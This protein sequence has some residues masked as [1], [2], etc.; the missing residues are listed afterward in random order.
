M[1]ATCCAGCENDCFA[2]HRDS[3]WLDESSLEPNEKKIT[4]AGVRHVLGFGVVF[5]PP[6]AHKGIAIAC[7][8]NTL[9]MGLQENHFSSQL[10]ACF[11]MIATTTKTS[12]MRLQK[13]PFQPNCGVDSFTV[14]CEWLTWSLS[15]LF[16]GMDGVLCH[17]C[18]TLRKIAL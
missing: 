6:V 7:K 11:Q 5:T 3:C 14:P 15:N 2:R 16:T 8:R 10:D 13:I 12:W 1:R 18:Q 17:L 4:C 9:T